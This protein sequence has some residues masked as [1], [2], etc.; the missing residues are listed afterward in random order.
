M[1]H[2]NV[3]YV[4]IRLPTV[5]GPSLLLRRHEK[6]GDWSLVGGHV[7]EWE[8]DD[9]GL[10]AAREATEELEP[11][12]NGQDFVVKPITSE[13]ITWGPE[14]SRSAKGQRTVYHIKYYTLTF[15]RD[16]VELLARLP[17]T[18]FLLVPERALDSA[19]HTLGSPV[20][21]ARHCLDGGF[22]AAHRAWTGELDSRTFP[23]GL[24]PVMPAPGAA[25]M[26]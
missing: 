2:S 10:A 24:Q 18:E 20:H 12:V 8:M 3:V 19:G 26:K 9:W 15:L 17:A 1:R 22:E 14:P 25:M 7:E 11:L 6:W 23:A 5:D 13:P 4:L 16:P 21:R